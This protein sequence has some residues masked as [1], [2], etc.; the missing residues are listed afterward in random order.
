MKVSIC[1]PT[2]EMKGFGANYLDH[3]LSVL[4]KQTY[5][6]FEVIISDHST[7]PL[8]ENVCKKYQSKFRDRKSGE[9]KIVDTNI[10]QN[11][12]KG[13]DAFLRKSIYNQIGKKWIETARML[14]N[15]NII[16]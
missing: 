3:S 1:I 10:A 4:E 14:K 9:I 15:A 8:I 12:Q 16:K 7:T 5:Q 11:I 6:N 2:Y 13:V